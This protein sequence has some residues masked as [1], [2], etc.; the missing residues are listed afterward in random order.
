LQLASAKPG[1]LI[2]VA[3]GTGLYP[4]SDLIDL[5]CKELL[6]R[7]KPNTID[8]IYRLS[9]VL[10]T[11]SFDQF[12]FELILSFHNISDIHPITLEQLIFLSN[13]HPKFN[14]TMKIDE[15]GRKRLSSTKIL[16]RSGAF[17]NL[18]S[19]ELENIKNISKIY[20]CGPPRMNE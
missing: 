10:K 18:I 12:F 19:K 20:V 6:V 2:I 5:L 9:P 17:D 7:M 15:E 3:G 8:T 1:K 11:R 4:F 13:N 16:F 14:L